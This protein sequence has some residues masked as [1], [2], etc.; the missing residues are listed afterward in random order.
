MHLFQFQNEFH[1]NMKRR[2]VSGS[3]DPFDRIVLPYFVFFKDWS[4][5]FYR[6]QYFWQSSCRCIDK[7]TSLV[8][9]IWSCHNRCIAFLLLKIL[10]CLILRLYYM[11][12]GQAGCYGYA[13]LLEPF[14]K[15]GTNLLYLCFPAQIK[16]S[17][18]CWVPARFSLAAN[19]D[20]CC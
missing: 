11:P 8:M 14:G 18:Q 17:V 2:N 5:F 10:K 12:M 19:H 16:V 13:L 20:V 15:S 1:F 9:H 3:R 6:R 4:A 7:P